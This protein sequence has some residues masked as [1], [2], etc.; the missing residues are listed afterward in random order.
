MSQENVQAMRRLYD[1]FNSGDLD[2]FEQ[3]VGRDLVWNE[4]DNSLY[5]GGNP[6]RSFAAVRDGVFAP[7]AR[8]F[9]SFRVDLEQLLDAGDHV[10]GTGRYRGKCKDTGKELSTQFCHLLHVD[11]D[12]KLDRVQEY[13]DTL[14]EAVVTGRTQL[15]EMKIPQPAM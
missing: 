10:I 6:Y 15:L 12:G 11:S 2:T 1:A 14:D 9:D 8:D 5:S 3:G 13:A 4:A 7:T